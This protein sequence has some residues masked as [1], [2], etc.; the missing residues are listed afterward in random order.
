MNSSTTNSS[1]TTNFSS[2]IV[3]KPSSS[4]VS[5]PSS[6]NASKT[7]SN[8]ASKPSSNRTIP[9]N[10]ASK[11]SSGRISKPSSGR[12]SKPMS[13]NI[14]KPISS[15]RISK[16]MSLNISRPMSLNISKPMSV[17]I[18]KPLSGS[19][20]NSSLQRSPNR[21]D[22]RDEIIEEQ[23]IPIEPLTLRDHQ[24]NHV[25]RLY[26]M[27]KSNSA[28]L[29]CS[30]AG[31]GKSYTCSAI[32]SMFH[33]PILIIAP[34]PVLPV[35]KKIELNHGVQFIDMISYSSLV[36]RVGCDLKHSYLTRNGRDYVSTS[37]LRDLISKGVMF[38]FDEM[39][40]TKNL[41]T[42]TFKAIHTIVREV[43]SPN[44]KSR[45]INASA[46][47]LDDRVQFM[48]LCQVL[49]LVRS[50]NYWHYDNQDK[51]I[52]TGIVELINWCRV[53]DWQRTLNL[54]QPYMNDNYY[55]LCRNRGSTWSINSLELMDLNKYTIPKLVADLF[56]L[57]IRDAI[58]HQMRRSDIES[59]SMDQSA[60][61][62]NAFYRVK[63]SNGIDQVDNSLLKKG[64]ELLRSAVEHRSKRDGR[65]VI[66]QSEL[67]AGFRITGNSMLRVLY[68]IVR[69]ALRREPNRKFII[70]VWYIS[71]IKWL[72]TALSNFNTKTLYGEIDPEERTN[73]IQQFQADN[74]EC[75]V[76]IANPMIAAEGIDLDDQYGNRPRTML[77]V[78]GNRFMKLV[79]FTHRVW[80]LNTKSPNRTQIHIIYSSQ[81][82]TQR[83]I[84]DRLVTKSND[85]RMVIG[86]SELKLPSEYDSQDIDLSVNVDPNLPPLPDITTFNLSITS[87]VIHP[88]N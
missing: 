22:N 71:H 47:P 28:V 2:S 65:S 6:N 63:D 86:N 33:M 17:N 76:I 7:L 42:L 21:N 11:P 4:I 37:Y 16:P 55:N 49:G 84:M 40:A 32:A 77:I 85:A 87:S 19:V 67:N 14:S 64:G 36:G 38:V 35:W 72:N 34:G 9:S 56:R 58:C 46:I 60:P 73:I 74:D 80:R 1:T 41:D 23:D 27:L 81:M 20:S 13:L 29:D 57:V 39:A 75:Q 70:G 51:Y 18:S 83:D 24:V 10:N 59:K 5:K 69:E 25:R 82:R 26:E 48:T 88:D 61:I 53:K 31:L 78:P 45:I 62:I 79:Q 68:Y 44:S 30:E 3:S 12:I 8:N 66:N 54:L 43:V 15:G 52:L 50:R